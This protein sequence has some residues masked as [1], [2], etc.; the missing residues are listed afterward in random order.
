MVILFF[1]RRLQGVISYNFGHSLVKF[2]YSRIHS[3]DHKK[4]KDNAQVKNKVGASA[5]PQLVCNFRSY[6]GK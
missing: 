5:H 3:D 6:L 1:V 4:E 2:S